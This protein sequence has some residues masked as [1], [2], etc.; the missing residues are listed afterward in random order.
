MSNDE[1]LVVIPREKLD[2]LTRAADYA[3]RLETVVKAYYA[4]HQDVGCTCVLC[5]NA[6]RVLASIGR[7][8]LGKSA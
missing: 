4:E 5:E 3:F 7:T 2:L 8:D 1:E 6:E